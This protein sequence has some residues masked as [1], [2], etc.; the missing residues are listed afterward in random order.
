MTGRVTLAGLMVAVLALVSGCGSHPA[1]SSNLFTVT[2]MR[3]PN[4]QPEILLKPPG[5]V[6]GLVLFEHGYGETQ[7]AIL[8]VSQL[9][10]LR[11]ALLSDGF[12]I[13]A[14]YSH[15]NNMGNGVSVD[16]QVALL[17]DAEQML[18]PVLSIDVVGFS[19]GGLDALMV[20]ARHVLP[21][22]K[23]VVV[24][25][26][27]CNQVPFLQTSLRGALRAAFGH[28]QGQQLLAAINPA[29][30]ERQNPQSFAGYRYWL[31][32]SPS[33]RIVPPAQASSMAAL[34][35]S[36]GVPVQLSLLDG[37]HGNLSMLQP[38]GIVQFF[39]EQ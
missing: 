27:I 9:F 29:D 16:D 12:A 23:G 20:A 26:G 34:L 31:W 39:Q 7:K 8:S 17:K 6:S 3:S 22:L 5:P 18:P 37:N 24:L 15:G 10:P 19:M 4:G 13:A 28:L 11:N 1:S 21:D 38:A 2:T 14:S 35:R 33:D 25:S 30:P 32:Q 36:A